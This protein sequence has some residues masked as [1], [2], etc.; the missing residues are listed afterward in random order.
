MK[1]LR[2][3]TG[4]HV[5]AAL[6]LAPGIH[7]IG[8]GSD[9]DINITDWSFAPLRLHVGKDGDGE[10]MAEWTPTEPAHGE[11]PGSA[12]APQPQWR[13]LTDFEPREFEGTVLCVGPAHGTWP[14]D[15][16]LLDAVFQ[17]TPQRVARWAGSKLRTRRVAALSAA[18][19]VALGLVVS[20]V[21]AGA[22]RPQAPVPTLETA[23]ASLQQE[24][25]SLQ[26]GQLQVKVEQTALVVSGLLDNADQ[27]TTVHAA[28]RAQRGP[29]TILPR[30][31]VASDVA[32]TIRSTVGL[33]NATVRHV[34]DGV[35]SYVAEAA[36][37]RAARAA[38]ERVSS[39]LAP[40]VKRIDATFEHTESSSGPILSRFTADGISVVQTRDGVK[41]LVVKSA[42]STRDALTLSGSGPP[43]SFQPGASAIPTK[44]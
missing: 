11:T 16:A 18:A 41:H 13:K 27:A 38:I 15:V 34:G 3:L 7:L 40:A 12:G 36:D 4:R 43:F 17:P 42:V 30:F 39:D 31:T 32:E 28:V 44:E 5:G 20:V 9:C 37:E 1:R 29:F 10:V 23:R 25:D 21:L 8:A 19:V 33:P 2:I 24:L 22:R 6:D 26:A 35:F 14:A